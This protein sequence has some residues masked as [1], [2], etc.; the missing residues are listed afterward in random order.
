MDYLVPYKTPR[1]KVHPWGFFPPSTSVQDVGV[2]HGRLRVLMT[3]QLLK[4]SNI[5]PVF[6]QV[7][8]EEVGKVRQVARFASPNFL[9]AS[10]AARGTAA[11]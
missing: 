8:S 9:T 3:E 11:W 7:Y 2:N 1:V 6:K 4:S 10:L 5:V